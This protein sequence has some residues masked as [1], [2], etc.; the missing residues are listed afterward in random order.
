MRSIA[1]SLHPAACAVE[2]RLRRR[3]TSAS[4]CSR[5]DHGQATDAYSSTRRAPIAS[6][7]QCTSLPR[8]R[9]SRAR[10]PRASVSGATPR[11]GAAGRKMCCQVHARMRDC[12]QRG[13]RRARTA[14]SAEGPRHRSKE[15]WVFSL[16]VLPSYRSGALTSLREEAPPHTASLGRGAPP[17]SCGSHNLRCMII[18]STRSSRT[19]QPRRWRS[20]SKSL[21]CG[22]PCAAVRRLPGYAACCFCRGAVYTPEPHGAERKAVPVGLRLLRY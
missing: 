11:S 8:A 5:L 2:H 7:M 14:V 6:E 9:A 3:P 20:A 16:P 22:L 19:S 15:F 4:A 17:S 18:Y 12:G 21:L 10:D 1:R 13:V